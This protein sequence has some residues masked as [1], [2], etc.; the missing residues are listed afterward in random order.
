MEAHNH[1]EPRPRRNTIMA[2]EVSRTFGEIRSI[3][4]ADERL[5]MWGEREDAIS[6]VGSFSH[7]WGD[8]KR[9][10]RNLG[11]K[12][13]EDDNVILDEE[14]Q[15]EDSGISMKEIEERLD[16]SHMFTVTAFTE[17][18]KNY[19]VIEG[20]M[21]LDNDDQTTRLIWELDEFGLEY[22]SVDG[23]YQFGGVG[24]PDLEDSFAV[25][26][27][28]FLFDRDRLF[29]VAEYFRRAYTQQSVLIHEA[30]KNNPAYL[31]FGNKRITDVGYLHSD[32]EIVNALEVW[33]KHN[34]SPYAFT[35]PDF[36][37]PRVWGGEPD[38]EHR[39]PSD[40]LEGPEYD[41]RDDPEHPD[42][43]PNFARSGARRKASINE[44]HNRRMRHWVAVKPYSYNQAMIKSSYD[45]RNRTMKER[46]LKSIAQ[47]RKAV[48]RP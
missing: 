31:I 20:Q 46:L 29:E 16:T 18:G 39:T 6:R 33:S 17:P 1:V 8:A 12:F 5:S 38:F 32:Q 3:S 13:D 22:I 25:F 35:P 24:D 37:K 14:G 41:P 42:Y 30:G 48:R 26:L 28:L 36:E 21:P 27:P 43:D 9:E 47:D 15:I 19:D 44:I 4:Q 45:R 40:D 34:E 11:V 2:R 10:G 23:L 7:A